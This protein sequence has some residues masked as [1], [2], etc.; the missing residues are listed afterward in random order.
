[1]RIH[2]QSAHDPMFTLMP[3]SAEE[4]RACKPESL[5][6][7][8]LQLLRRFLADS[9]PDTGSLTLPGQINRRFQQT[10]G[11]AGPAVTDT[12]TMPPQLD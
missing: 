12:H 4:G 11:H 5:L 8:K 2:Q 6:L 7:I 9:Q 1:M 10:Q 3:F